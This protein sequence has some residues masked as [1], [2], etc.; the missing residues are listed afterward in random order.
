MNKWIL[1]A[2]LSVLA[3]AAQAQ[4]VYLQGSQSGGGVLSSPRDA[5]GTVTAGIPYV[6]ADGSAALGATQACRMVHTGGAPNTS[7]TAANTNQTPVATEVYIAEILVTMPCTATGVSTYNGS[8]ASGNVKVGLA[9]RAGAVVATSA[10]TASA[11]T[12]VYQNVPF[13][14]T[15][16]LTPGTY[17]VLAFYDNNTVRPTAWTAG[18]FGASK[19]TG[20]TYAT[21]FT[22]I[23]PPTTFTTALG[24]VASLY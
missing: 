14:A 15:L 24:P 16:A 13:T 1:A 17:Y 20:Q 7:A 2:A 22:T 10:S 4:T 23:T 19:Q 18:A 21:G 6:N 9:N 11:G 3:I 12:T 8:V 5:T